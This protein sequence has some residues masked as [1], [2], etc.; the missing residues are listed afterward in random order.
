MARPMAFDKET[1]VDQAMRLIWR[2]GYEAS[3][4]KSLSEALGITRS[5]FYNTFGSRDD[6][7]KLALQRYLSVIPEAAL[8]TEAAEDSLPAFMTALMRDVCRMRTTE[9]KGMGCLAANSLAELLPSDT[10]AAK[11]IGDL[12]QGLIQRLSVLVAGAISRGEMSKDIDPN[13]MGLAVHGMIMGI[14]LQS[15]V[16]TN[17]TQ[18]WTSAQ[19]SLRG[20][21]LYKE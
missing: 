8:F 16:I 9:N 17:E 20:L 2:D 18:L 6:L 5:S 1:A 4:V 14:N 21:G 13:A 3:S 15:K 19:Q 7:F 11:S 12:T 10:E